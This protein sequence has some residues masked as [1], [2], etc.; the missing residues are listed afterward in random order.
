MDSL[1]WRKS[2]RLHNLKTLYTRNWKILFKLAALN[3]DFDEALT[4]EVLGDPTHNVV[5]H[6]LYIYSMECFIY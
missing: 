5:K 3:Y 2:Y 4:P 6:I 1:N